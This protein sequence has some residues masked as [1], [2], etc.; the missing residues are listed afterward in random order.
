MKRKNGVFLRYVVFLWLIVFANAAWAYPLEDTYGDQLVFANSIVN[1]DASVT[2]QQLSEADANQR[3]SRAPDYFDNGGT[4]FSLGVGG[5]MVVEFG[6]NEIIGGGNADDDLFI[7]EVEDQENLQVSLISNQGRQFDFASSTVISVP[8]NDATTGQARKT[9]I[10]Q[11]DIDS[12][13]GNLATGEFFQ[14]VKI[15]D[16]SGGSGTE[17]ADI[18]AIGMV[19][20]VATTIAAANDVSEPGT[21]VLLIGGFLGLLIIRLRRSL[22]ASSITMGGGRPSRLSAV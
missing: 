9:N 17:G 4:T 16:G 22:A 7:Y 6:D 12:L 1:Y 15:M 20:G 18:D 3:V 10:F 8:G 5:A 11:F 19:A 2:P 13:L 14:Y 21:V